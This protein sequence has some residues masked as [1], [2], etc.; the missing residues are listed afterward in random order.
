LRSSIEGDWLG[1][2]GLANLDG[3]LTSG[4]SVRLAK[5]PSVAELVASAGLASRAPS[6]SKSRFPW[7]QQAS[8]ELG[9]LV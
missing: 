4:A 2:V 7:S 6:P 9:R 8:R 5:P 3:A 1:R